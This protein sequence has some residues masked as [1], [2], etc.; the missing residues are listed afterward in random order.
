LPLSRVR[1]KDER[2]LLRIPDDA[3]RDRLA[4][5]QEN[6][7]PMVEI[8]LYEKGGDLVMDDDHLTYLAYLAL[9]IESVPAVV[10]GD[11]DSSG[12]EILETGR[13]ELIPPITIRRVRR[14]LS[15][16]SASA[17]LHKKIGALAP[18]VVASDALMNTFVRFCRLL[19]DD[20][21]HEKELHNFLNRN[22]VL[23]DCHAATMLSEVPIGRYR[24]DLI[25]RYHQLDKSILLVELESHRGHLMKQNL[26]LTY[27][28]THAYQQVEEW[29]REI[30]SD[31]K[32]VPQWLRGPHP[33]E[34]A[35]VMGRSR[36]LSIEQ[37][38]A[39]SSNNANR[40]VKILTYDDLLE[41]L[42]R[43]IFSTNSLRA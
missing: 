8:V 31:A 42:R 29:I 35:V 32:G 43:L 39:I 15:R 28:V 24:A 14:G 34:G 40:L 20:D 30:R 19:A 10:V 26:R 9:K 27:K 17:L 37:R 12:I 36:D 33:I 6:G 1:P 25:V 11:F 16:E 18:R 7:M 2:Y 21:T 5:V 38:N 3:I 22:P 23:F 13:S 41:R 4:S